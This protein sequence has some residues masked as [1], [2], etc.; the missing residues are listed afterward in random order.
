MTLEEV[1][2]WV[3]RLQD[4]EPIGPTPSQ[5][6]DL[7]EAVEELEPYWFGGWTDESGEVYGG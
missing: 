4:G 2:V 1:N 3:K 6:N 5:F 7:I